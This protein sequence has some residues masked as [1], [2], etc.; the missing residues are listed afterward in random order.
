MWMIV[1]LLFQ[2]IQDFCHQY[3]CTK[4][5]SFPTQ[6]T[7]THPEESQI[8]WKHQ[9]KLNITICQVFASCSKKFFLKQMVKIFLSGVLK[10][11][12][13]SFIGH[14]G[15][16]LKEELTHFEDSRQSNQKT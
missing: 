9:T 7:A 3:I 5:W 1:L 11:K 14:L 2:N 12:A 16:V 13:V 10:K 15:Q 4:G 8:I 6:N